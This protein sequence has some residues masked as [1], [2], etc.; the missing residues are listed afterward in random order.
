M[1]TAPDLSTLTTTLDNL[2]RRARLMRQAKGAF[3]SCSDVPT[4]LLVAATLS[5]FV[6]ARDS[7]SSSTLSLVMAIVIVAGWVRLKVSAR[8]DAIVK[9]LSGTAEA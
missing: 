1:T 6:A 2:E 7:V 8:L 9:L 3:L 4:L 5:T